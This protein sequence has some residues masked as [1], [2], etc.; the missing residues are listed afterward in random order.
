MYVVFDQGEK[1]EEA[2]SAATSC[3]GWHPEV[4]LN[5]EEFSLQIWG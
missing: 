1:H 4:I 3:A 5:I 2:A